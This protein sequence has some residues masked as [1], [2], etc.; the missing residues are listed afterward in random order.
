MYPWGVAGMA[1]RAKEK[2]DGAHSAAVLGCEDMFFT[3][4]LLVCSLPFVRNSAS[5]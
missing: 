1:Q 3:F 5:G 4:V 2:F